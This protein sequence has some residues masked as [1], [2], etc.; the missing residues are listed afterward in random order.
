MQSVQLAIA[1][2]RYAAMVREALSRSCAWHVEIGRAPGPV[3]ERRLGP[4]RTGIR[5]AAPPPVQS[6]TRR[7]DRAQRAPGL[8]IPGAGM[9]SRHPFRG[10]GRRFHQYRVAGHHGGGPPC[11]KIRH[12]RRCERNYPQS[13]SKSA[14][15]APLKFPS[16]P[17][18]CRIHKLVVLSLGR[19][20]ALSLIPK[21]RTR[22]WIAL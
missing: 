19:P 2:C 7:T 4:G 16:D 15:I 5:A 17:K 11:R 8:R 10:L 18:R 21:R 12:N 6:R 3:A 14:S 22:R 20:R 9:G 13:A 1:D